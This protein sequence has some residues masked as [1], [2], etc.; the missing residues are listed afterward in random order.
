M[1]GRKDQRSL[2]WKRVLGKA[3][4]GARVMPEQSFGRLGNLNWK[5]NL[6]DIEN[7]MTI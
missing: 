5:T 2:R 3:C 6:F 4:L 1:R 7:L